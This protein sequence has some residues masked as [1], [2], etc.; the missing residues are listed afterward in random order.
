MDT[1]KQI[2]KNKDNNVNDIRD[3]PLKKDDRK[4][5]D[6]IQRKTYTKWIN[7]ILKNGGSEHEVDKLCDDLAD[8]VILAELFKIF[9]DVTLSICKNRNNK[10][11]VCVSNL[12]IVLDAFKGEGLELVNN[13]PSDIVEG[14][15]SIVLGL[16]WQIILHYEVKYNIDQVPMAIMESGSEASVCSMSVGSPD[17]SLKENEEKTPKKTTKFFSKVMLKWIQKE[18]NEPYGLAINNFSD[19]WK[20]GVAFNALLHR[21]CPM[22]V[23]MELVKRGSPKNNLRSVFATAEKYFKIAPLLDVEDILYLTAEKNSIVMYVSQFMKQDPNRMVEEI[24]EIGEDNTNH[25][26]LSGNKPKEMTENKTSAPNVLYEEKMGVSVDDSSSGQ[27]RLEGERIGAPVDTF[28]NR[29]VLEEETHDIYEDN[30]RN[31]ITLDDLTKGETK[32]N[33]PIV[34]DEERMGGPVDTSFGPFSL[35]EITNETSEVGTSSPVASDKERKEVIED[36]FSD[37]IASDEKAT[38]VPLDNLLTSQT[39]LSR[40]IT[41]KYEDNTED[42]GVLDNVPKEMSEENTSDSIVL[43]AKQIRV[44]EDCHSIS[45]GLDEE[46]NGVPEDCHSI[47]LGLDE[48]RSGVPED[49]TSV[50]IVSDE[51]RSGVPEDITSV[52][53][54]LEGK[55]NEIYESKAEDS[56]ILVEQT[57]GKA[58]DSAPITVDEEIKGVP[59]DEEIKGVPVD[60]EIKGVPVDE[61][62]MGVPVDEEIIGV[63]VNNS[64]CDQFSLEEEIKEL[65][66]DNVEHEIVLKEVITEMPKDNV[67]AGI[68]LDEETKELLKDNVETGIVLDDEEKQTPDN[69]SLPLPTLDEERWTTDFDNKIDLLDVQNVSTI[70]KEAP[71]SKN[72][73][74][75]L[76]NEDPQNERFKFYFLLFAIL[77]ILLSMYLFVDCSAD[78]NENCSPPTF[79]N[80]LKRKLRISR[81]HSHVPY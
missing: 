67:E 45:I 79:F 69:T 72:N 41:E 32:D 26:I 61:E 35:D 57:K 58:R 56:I 25:V 49:I 3:S 19:A 50:P 33:T 4:Y 62:I 42:L 43:D 78:C 51:E 11:C 2:F 37:L 7:H 70:V 64:I 39:H 12:K 46:R 59:V 77:A 52:P 38:V 63:P 14:K 80:C 48:E 44:P 55:M 60:E 36:N 66:K 18:I 8:G 1:F 15:E 17:R 13:N 74:E 40:G 27:I 24:H 5:M 9:R 65:I 73:A 34:V 71:H 10:K 31:R 81:T 54:V 21:L 47:S 28:S 75:V 30:V 16:V 23:N 29:I 20:D 6:T 22:L 68:V 53:I 76:I